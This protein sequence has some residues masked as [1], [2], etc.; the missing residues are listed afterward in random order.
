MLFLLSGAGA[1]A[2]DFLASRA[3]QASSRTNCQA[4]GASAADG[5]CSSRAGVSNGHGPGPATGP[6]AGW[7]P[8]S[9]CV[10]GFLIQNH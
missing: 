8:L 1:A 4:G 3:A 9:P 5:P 2:L 7:T 10:L 6:S